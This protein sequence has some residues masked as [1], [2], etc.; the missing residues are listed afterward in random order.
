M[1]E[2]EDLTKQCKLPFVSKKRA[3]L[4]EVKENKHHRDE[5]A[6]SNNENNK[7][8]KIQNDRIALLGDEN[9]KLKNEN[10]YLQTLQQKAALLQLELQGK[11]GKIVEV[12]NS[13]EGKYLSGVKW[14]LVGANVIFDEEGF[15]ASGV[16]IV[17]ELA[18]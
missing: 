18:Y 1:K 12:I 2:L 4:P 15:V 13:C 9:N 17:Y 5:L 3:S 14:R 7:R 16:K 10:N 11:I 6:N 8:H